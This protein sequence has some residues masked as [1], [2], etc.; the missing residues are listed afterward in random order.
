MIN[1]NDPNI[2]SYKIKDLKGDREKIVIVR[3][4]SEGP[5]NMTFDINMDDELMP[6]P[7]P[8]APEIIRE[9]N[10]GESQIKII[11]KEK[12]MEGKNGKEIEVQVETE[13]KK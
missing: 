10:N 6:P 1:L 3:K 8:E 7:P 2:I 4:K 12:K 11:R 9:F 5:E 13:D